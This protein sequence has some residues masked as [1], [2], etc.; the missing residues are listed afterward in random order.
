[1]SWVG[2]DKT[3]L[4][5]RF[6]ILN[7]VYLPHAD[8]VVDYRRYSP[9]NTFRLLFNLYFKTNLELL[10]NHHYYTTWAHPF[11]FREIT[12]I[13]DPAAYDARNFVNSPRV[14]Y[15][16]LNRPRKQGTQFNAE[17]CCLVGDN[18]VIIEPLQK[19][20]VWL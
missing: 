1:M 2:V 4:Q 6:S 10:P 9:V 14:A 13:L 18:G 17:G 12:R 16:K 20:L 3:N 5:E 11:K 8:K 7:A 15:R 19:N